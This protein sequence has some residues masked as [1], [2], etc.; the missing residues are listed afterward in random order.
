M[1]ADPV[2]D[3]DRSLHS[4]IQNRPA[5]EEVV[6]VAKIPEGNVTRS[7]LINLIAS[8]NVAP[9]VR[10]GTRIAR[11]VALLN[12]KYRDQRKQCILEA[13]FE[14]DSNYHLLI[15]RGRGQCIDA[16]V[17]CG[18]TVAATNALVDA[19]QVHIGTLRETVIGL[20][21]HLVPVRMGVAGWRVE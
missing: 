14:A 6:R 12:Q 20:R 13:M 7:C 17:K 1:F 16:G 9:A 18:D 2:I 5:L 8:A 19:F 11:N 3:S 21:H 4:T 15:V 10:Y